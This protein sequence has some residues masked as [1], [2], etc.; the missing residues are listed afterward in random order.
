MRFLFQSVIRDI[1]FLALIFSLWSSGCRTDA[2]R[3]ELIL[4]NGAV[5]TV[6][7]NRS[8]AEAVAVA[9]GR[10]IYVG[11]NAGV[12]KFRGEQTKN[13]DLAGKMV[14]PGFH[15]SHV[16]PVSGGIELG[17][18]NLNGLTEQQEIFDKVRAYAAQHPDKAWIVG[19]GWDLPIFPNANPTK[20]M[21][22]QIVPDRPVFLSA[23]DGHSAWVNSQAL[24]IAGINKDTADPPEGR[25]ERDPK[26]G[27]P[28]GTLREQATDL[29]SGHLPELTLED[30]I[31][32]AR[33]GLQMANR[34]GITSLQ[35]ASA[36]EKI[37]EA[38]AELD[39]RGELTARVLAAQYVDPKKDET[40][41][42]E[43]QQRRERFHGR[44][45]HATAA[46]IFADGVIES[47]TAA[48]LEPYLDRPDYRGI[49]NLKAEQF[50]RLA[51]ALDSAGFQIHIHAIG[52]RAIRMALDALEAAQK[53]NGVRDARH[54]IAHLELINPNDLPRFKALGVVATFQPLWAYADLYI[55]AL[56][57]P[58][59]G[60]ERSRWLY[61]IASVAQTGAIIAAGSDW[62]VSSM[63]PVEAMQVAITRSALDDSTGPAWIPEE[64]VDLP[65][66][67]AAYTINGAFVNHQEKET[68]SIEIGKAAD[69]IV[70]DRNLF[71]IQAHEIHRAKVLLTLLEGKE[72]YRDQSFE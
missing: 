17:Q 8:W 25:I 58:A 6:D 16:H 33:A 57:E 54:H 18:C 59:L 5:Y 43:L 41:I 56:T 35:E 38:Y 53:T 49:P 62:S 7:G 15:D 34:F 51:L 71:K 46:K 26:I 20:E 52:D 11:D 61:P 60:P 45:L 70:L 29:I 32:G 22:D 69:L 48:M 65:T 31:N 2:Q 13:I 12:E 50:D 27:E 1:F 42:L 66:M 40:Q 68:G 55:T 3:A 36:H 63:N 21:L 19:G 23:A 10:I 72:V 30:H 39:R 14:L 64:L 67:I 24:A 37:L 28:S 9:K 44:Y 4:S 47:R